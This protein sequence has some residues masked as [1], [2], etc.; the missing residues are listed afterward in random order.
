MIFCL[1]FLCHFFLSLLFTMGLLLDIVSFGQHMRVVFKSA[2]RNVDESFAPDYHELI[3]F[4]CTQNSV[5]TNSGKAVTRTGNDLHSS[6]KATF[7]DRGGK[8]RPSHMLL[9][10]LRAGRVDVSILLVD[11]FAR[12]FLVAAK[13][14]FRFA[15]H[16]H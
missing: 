16:L 10:L 11:I 7:F 15:D 8:Q 2:S 9:L 1:Q 5:K 12:F 3:K 6:T 14:H 4:V 13:G